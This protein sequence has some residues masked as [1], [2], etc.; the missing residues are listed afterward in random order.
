MHQPIHKRR[1][2]RITSFLL[3]L[4][5]A[6]GLYRAIRPDP[7]LKKVKKLQE[8]FATAAK[9]W[10]PEQRQ[11]KGQEMRMAMSQLSSSQRDALSADRQKKMQGDLERYHA[12]SPTEKVRHLDEQINR[13]EQMRQQFAQRNPGGQ[14]RPAGPP[15]GNNR[16]QEERDKNR[17]NRLNNTTPEFRTLMDQFRKDMSARRQQR[18]LSGGGPRF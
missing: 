3:M 15:G 14:Q 5:A 9:D 11:Q 7:N 17:K 18:G 8:E 1:W 13:Q 6:Y 2:I 10:T 16:S 12:M 4:V